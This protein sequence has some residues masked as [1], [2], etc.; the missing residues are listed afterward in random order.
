MLAA[1]RLP[2]AT[3]AREVVATVTL[4]EGVSTFTSGSDGILPV[5]PGHAASRGME[6]GSRTIAA[7]SPRDPETGAPDRRRRECD[8]GGE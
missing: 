5:A 6:R 1:L 2:L 4:A 7:R 8:M 3:T